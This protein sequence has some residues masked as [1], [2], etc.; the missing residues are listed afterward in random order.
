MQH[1]ITYGAANGECVG[2]KLNVTEVRPENRLLRIV[3]EHLR[4]K[5]ATQ[6]LYV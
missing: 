3:V 1:K 2:S 6:R 5:R 4:C